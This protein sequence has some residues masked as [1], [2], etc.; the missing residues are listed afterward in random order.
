MFTANNASSSSTMMAT[1]RTGRN[2]A[3]SGR[4]VQWPSGQPLTRRSRVGQRLLQGLLARVL[5]ELGLA[6]RGGTD[7][8]FLVLTTALVRR[9][10]AA[11]NPRRRS[12]TRG[13]RAD[14]H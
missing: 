6:V 13:D 5:R 2:V 11:R 3:G 9:D 10:G 8:T 1:V 7:K 4:C 14:G 12:G